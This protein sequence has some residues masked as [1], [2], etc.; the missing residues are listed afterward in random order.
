MGF[1]F[2]TLAVQHAA[3]HGISVLLND[4]K[5]DKEQ[6]YM[7]LQRK[8]WADGADVPTRSHHLFTGVPDLLW[9]EFPTAERGPTE[10]F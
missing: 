1:I 3:G 2:I 10:T 9:C 8:E 6:G 5:E 7:A 4:L